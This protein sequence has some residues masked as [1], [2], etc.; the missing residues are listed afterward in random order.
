M[1][2]LTMFVYSKHACTGRD[3]YPAVERL[4]YEPHLTHFLR[5][6]VL[7][8]ELCAQPELSGTLRLTASWAGTVPS[9]DQNN[10]DQYV[11]QLLNAMIGH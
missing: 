8:C 7:C 9:Q 6:N 4:R 2:S 10:L 3:S 11:P 5:Q 1:S